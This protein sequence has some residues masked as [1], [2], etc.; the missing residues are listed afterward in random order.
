MLARRDLHPSQEE[1]CLLGRGGL[2]P[3]Q[4]GGGGVCLLARGVCILAKR[5]SPS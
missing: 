4:G 3:S 2:R 5:G 1:V